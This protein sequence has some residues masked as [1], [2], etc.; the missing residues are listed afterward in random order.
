MTQITPTIKIILMVHAH[1][2]RE[3]GWG[4]GWR[5][6]GREHRGVEKEGR[7]LAKNK[8]YSEKDIE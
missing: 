8:A 5:E 3:M 2:K 7:H 1:T 6:G 4:K